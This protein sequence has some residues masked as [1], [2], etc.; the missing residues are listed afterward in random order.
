[1]SERKSTPDILGELL[2]GKEEPERSGF[3]PPPQAKPKPKTKPAAEYVEKPLPQKTV[4]EKK[5][6]WEYR[7]I[8]FQDYQGWRP[9]FLDGKEISNWSA[10]PLLQE[11]LRLMGDEGW[12]LAAAASGESM[13]GSMDKYQLF[14]MRKK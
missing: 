13:H 3:I 7:V 8:S 2:A 10:G 11:F 6:C 9:R 1:M 5:D 4:R 12:Q 14:F